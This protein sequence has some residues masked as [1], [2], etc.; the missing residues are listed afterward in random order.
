[1]Y[2]ISTLLA[3]EEI[4]QVLA[5]YCRGIDRGDLELLKSVYHEDAS[6]QHGPFSGSGWE[7]AEFVVAAMKEKTL[8]TQHHITNTYIEVEGATA[9]VES[10][11]LAFSPSV[12]GEGEP[13]LGMIGGRYLDEFSYRDGRWAIDKRMVVLDFGRDSLGGP[14]WRGLS[15][16]PR[17]N[18]G[19]SDLSAA[20]FRTSS[21]KVE[22]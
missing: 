22:N 16:Y 13:S 11:F 21:S 18:I 14:E 5:A 15:G 2:E 12:F 1:M 4:R 17:G 8:V 7:F 3:H 19:D 10:Y 20:L 6:D 9:A